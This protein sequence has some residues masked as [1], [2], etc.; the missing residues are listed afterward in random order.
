ML[1]WVVTMPEIIAKH[2]KE[3]KTGGL[4]WLVTTRMAAHMVSNHA[5]CHLWPILPDQ[6][7]DVPELSKIQKKLI[8]KTP[9]QLQKL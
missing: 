6:P 4:A 2:L 1:A 5:S 3:L 9:L 7:S 8:F